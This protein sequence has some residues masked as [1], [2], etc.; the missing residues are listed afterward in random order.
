MSLLQSQLAQEHYDHEEGARYDDIRERYASEIEDMRHWAEADEEH[1]NYMQQVHEAGF[2][3]DCDA[4]EANWKR[5]IMYCDGHF[6]PV[7]PILTNEDIESLYVRYI[8][9]VDKRSI[10]EILS[11]KECF[12]R[13]DLAT[14]AH[15]HDCLGEDYQ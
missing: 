13:D 7:G 6:I 3:E 1:S 10:S 14:W 8:Q 2:G 4:Y 12:L 15:E 9:P 5:T 11:L